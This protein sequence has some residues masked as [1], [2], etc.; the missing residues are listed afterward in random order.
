MKKGIEGDWI[1]DLL[2]AKV[3][4]VFFSIHWEGHRGNLW[5]WYFETPHLVVSPVEREM[6][7]S[8]LL[9]ALFTPYDNHKAF[10]IRLM[11][12]LN[13]KLNSFFRSKCNTE[14]HIY[15]CRLESDSS[16]FKWLQ[17]ASG[18][19]IWGGACPIR[20]VTIWQRCYSCLKKK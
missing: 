14:V 16:F 2:N 9:S 5:H 10:C 13:I 18:R 3:K 12:Q 8:I 19:S 1:C 15:I 7:V 6:P 4:N 20:L 17:W 11:I